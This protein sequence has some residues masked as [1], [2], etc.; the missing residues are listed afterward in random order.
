MIEVYSYVLVVRS[1][2]VSYARHQASVLYAAGDCTQK[3]RRPLDISGLCEVADGGCRA[4]P[5]E[6]QR[7]RRPAAEAGGKRR[8]KVMSVGRWHR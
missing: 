6:R 4:V 5:D 8:P 1:R 2:Q 3:A 7:I